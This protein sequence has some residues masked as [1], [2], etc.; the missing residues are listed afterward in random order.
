MSA[1][2]RTARITSL[3]GAAFLLLSNEGPV[4]AQRQPLTVE[5]IGSLPYLSGT[6]PANPVWS[7]DSTR[8]AFLWNDE[9]MPFRDV[10]VVSA[11]GENPK[12]IT[13][14]AG[15]LPSPDA[16]GKDPDAILVQEV[17]ARQHR[18]VS[19]VIWT[20]DGQALIFA[21]QTTMTTAPRN[22]SRA[23]MPGAGDDLFQVNAD[24]TGLKRLT[25]SP[26]DKYGLSFSPDGQLLAFLQ[27][28]DLWLGKRE[29]DE[30]DEPVRATRVA[31]PAIGQALLNTCCGPGYSRPDVELSSYR[32]SP[33]G[34]YIAF[35]LND[36]RQIRKVMIPNYLGEET[37]FNFLRRDY[38]GDNDHVRDVA[39]YSVSG[40]RLVRL[41]LPDNTDRSV[42]HY[43]W[44]PD[45]SRLLVDQFDQSAENR[46]I[47]LAD[48]TDG[49][50]QEIWHDHRATRTS[51]AWSS[52]WQSDGRGIL[53]S[54]DKDD[55]HHLYAL[56]LGERE[57][58]RLTRGDWSVIGESGAAR[59][60]VSRATK[61]VYF[62][63]NKKSPYERH[64]Y[65]M[66]ENGGE[67]V[68]VTSL[69]GVHHPYWAPDASKIALLH[70]NDLT[71]TELYIVSSKGG[72]PEQRVTHSPSKDFYD[73]DWIEPRYVT[74]PSHIDG[75]TVHG[76]ILEPRNLD[77]S[78][79][80]PVIVGPVYP[81]S[82]KNRWGA[83]E[84]W[85][86]L[87]STLQQYFTL[88][89]EYIGLLVDVRGTFGYG[90]AFREKLFRD[91]GG[92]DIED[93]H[94]GVQYLLTLPYV[95]RERIGIWGSSYGGLMTAMS[96]FKKPGVYTAGVASAP[97]THITH[98]MTG[99]VN[100]AGRPNTHPEVYRKVSAI[101]YGEDL[102]DHLM[103]MHGM[104][105]NVVLFKDSVTLAEKLMML[106]K[107]FDFVVLPNVPHEWG[108]KD[109]V[110]LYG[111]RK[112]VGHFDRY[113]GRGPR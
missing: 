37:H 91:Y 111:L 50:L 112:L 97:A 74:F 12:R 79:K 55:R 84:E 99:Q 65:R 90:R 77:R 32:W 102:E 33:D 34:R 48:P 92:I 95:D 13:D 40:G 78:K 109:Y 85:R 6:A 110:S 18:G 96:L 106:G 11:S 107:D 7:P 105:D 3:L 31:R 51:Q 45:G 54:S 67:I 52:A 98:A 9:A 20:P 29:N 104:Q 22:R 69:P 93:I 64:V 44:S 25:R 30:L 5:R 28:G 47:Y 86:G 68:Q 72:E 35:H 66:P 75:V 27:E 87:H 4:N 60:F 23:P 62:V 100:V 76:R 57:P 108:A 36:R 21:V 38:P 16:L 70:S 2:V 81:N 88:E 59:I 89:G 94:S 73:H 41:N 61:E 15:Q 83:R 14:M 71:P 39:I 49:S 101:N 17:T 10:W 19:E 43:G 42:S 82:V 46:W 80:Y 24:G 103:I 113:L 63:A 58:K 53:F 56:R 26:E 1:S 8:L